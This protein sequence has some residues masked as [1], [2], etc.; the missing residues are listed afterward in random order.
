IDDPWHPRSANSAPMTL[1]MSG[2]QPKLEDLPGIVPPIKR[3]QELLN[4]EKVIFTGSWNETCQ[5]RP[6]DVSVD[7]GGL[8]VRA[9]E[10][11]EILRETNLL[12][13][14]RFGLSLVDVIRRM[15][16]AL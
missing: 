10:C 16:S 9:E 15:L 4:S 6:G 12:I 14:D 8:K 7:T 13:T 11:L 2:R 3:V 5:V 1:L